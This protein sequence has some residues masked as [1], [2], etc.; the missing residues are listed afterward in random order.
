[1]GD[2]TNIWKKVLWSV[3]TKIELFGDQ[4]KCYVWHKPTPLITPRI[5]SPQWQHHAVGIFLIDRD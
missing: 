1:V 5:P 3:E 2:S 4:G